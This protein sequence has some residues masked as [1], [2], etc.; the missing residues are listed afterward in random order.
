[1]KHHRSDAP[2]D[3]YRISSSIKKLRI[4]S[5][6]QCLFPERIPFQKQLPMVIS[7][8][9]T[10]GDVDYS[11]V[12]SP[13]L[14]E[15][16]FMRKLRKIRKQTIETIPNTVH[17]ELQDSICNDVEQVHMDEDDYVEMDEGEGD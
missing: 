2:D 17:Q 9:E 4:D 10:M 5:G 8:G 1:M 6:E 3:E 13:I 15:L 14:K 16:A 7:N 11:G 12:V